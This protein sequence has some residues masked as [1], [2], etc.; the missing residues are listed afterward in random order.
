MQAVEASLRRLATDRIDVYFVHR[1]DERTPIDETLRAL[2]D[3]VQQ[4]KILYP[5]R[6]QLGGVADREGA[7]HLGAA[8]SLA[9]FECSS[10]C[11]TWSSARPRW[12]SCRWRRAEQLGVI[13]YSPLGGGLLS[14][15]YGDGHAAGAGGCSR[16][17]MYRTRYGEPEYLEIAERFT[18][19]AAGAGRASGDAG[20][21]VGHGASR[22]S[23]RRSSARE[24]GAAGSIVAGRR[25]RDDA[26]VAGGD[27]GALP[28]TAARN[29][30]K[31]GAAG[32]YLQRG[33]G[34]GIQRRSAQIRQAHVNFCHGDTE[35]TEDNPFFLRDLRAS[36]VQTGMQCAV[37]RDRATLHPLQHQ[38]QRLLQRGLERLEELGDFG[39]IGHAMIG[40]ARHLHASTHSQLAV[41]VHHRDLPHRAHGQRRGLR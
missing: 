32:D 24:P 11:T 10:R 12:R 26:G 20:G 14:G 27:L 34:E 18:A 22:P 9:R 29:R 39:A 41:G 35:F 1:F 21:G 15:K 23:P 38:P 5:R 31:R 25:S 16:A 13:P 37:V 19:H 30:P 17:N 3:L 40:R 6:Q 28:R 36:V 4:G 2:D 8:M 33:K 7:G